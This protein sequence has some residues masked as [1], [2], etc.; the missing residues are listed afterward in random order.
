MQT[1]SILLSTVHTNPYFAGLIASKYGKA[2][3][4]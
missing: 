1:V 4:S 3:G 2:N